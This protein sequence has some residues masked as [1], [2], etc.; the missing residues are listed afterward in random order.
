MPLSTITTNSIADD[1]ITVP[2]VT[3]Q[4]LTNRNLIINGAMQV[5]QRGTSET[6]VTTS[7]YKQAPDRFVFG[8]SSLGT[9]TISQSTDAPDGFSNSYKIECTAADASPAPSNYFIFQ[10]RFEGQNLQHLKYG[11][12]SAQSL[13]LSFWVKSNKIGTYIAEFFQPSGTSRH[14]NKA[15]T[16]N[17]ANTWEHKSITVVGDTSGV[18]D[19]NSGIGLYVI[20]WIGAGSDYNSGTLQTSWG[21]GNG[22]D[23]AVGNVNLADTIGNDWQIT[24]VQL[25]VGD[26]ATPFEH[27]SF[28]DELAR[29]QRYF[30]NY[31]RNT[32]GNSTNSDAY[33]SGVFTQQDSSLLSANIHHPVSMRGNPTVTFTHPGTMPS[34]TG[35]TITGF[36]SAD[37]WG[38][39]GGC[40]CSYIGWNASGSTG[41]S[42]R[43][44]ILADQELSFDAEL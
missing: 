29:C 14:I 6:G 21:I 13:T 25:E 18:I 2:K 8:L 22:Q 39:A 23:R 28:G 9:W 34:A 40:K 41:N 32:G 37:S 15:Y 11:T 36:N 38:S 31:I 1:A 5:A 35:V 3:D 43:L 12:S 17:S 16:I 24:G 27:R 20:W 44:Y 33:I 26:T 10:Q 7:G 30:Y 19:N 4:I 42:S